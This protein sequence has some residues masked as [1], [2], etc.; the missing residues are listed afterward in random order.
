MKRIIPYLFFITFLISAC[1]RPIIQKD[2]NK[3][4]LTDILPGIM[5]FI[6]DKTYEYVQEELEDY[7][8]AL[9]YDGLRPVLYV[10]AW[11]NPGEIRDSI[12]KRID[13]NPETEGTVFIGDI[14][15]PMIR[16]AQ[17]LTSAFKMD[18]VLF[19]NMQ[20]SSVASDRFYDDLDLRF[21]FIGQDTSDS[22]LFYYS[23]RADSP[24][25]I[26]K[27]IYSGRIISPRHS[28]QK[29]EDIA[30][31]LKKAAEEKYKENALDYAFTFAGHGYHS[32]A[33]S[34]WEDQLYM[35]KDQFPQ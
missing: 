4:L 21:D 29:Y 31:Y 30:A 28:D 16:D 34:A 27:D 11:E 10:K 25:R 35:L 15:I 18:Q 2:T 26:E 20:Q 7:L 9:E 12:Q 3:N 1:G 8:K 14:P 23:L 19:K 22:R 6:D 5:V 17:H 24:Q 32:E 33:L 13:E